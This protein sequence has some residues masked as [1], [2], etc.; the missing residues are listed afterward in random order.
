MAREPASRVATRPRSRLHPRWDA[1]AELA[2]AQHGV[3]G[4]FQLLDLG[5]QPR[6]IS[7]LLAGG[8]L[9]QIHRGVY[10]VGHRKL[11]RQGWRMAAVLSGGEGAALSHRPAG[12]EWQL[13][14]WSGRQTITVPSWR[15]SSSEIDFRCSMPA[16]DE[17]TVLDGIPITTVPRTLLDLAMVL[18]PDALLVAV[19]VAEA[20]GMGD[21]LS[22]P[23][24]LERH[25]GERGTEA[26]RIRPTVSGRSSGRSSSCTRP[27]GM[28]RSPRSH[29][30]R[31]VTGGC[32]SPTT[33]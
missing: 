21:T 10:A 9:H 1:I 28:G 5:F 23:D 6:A 14:N 7:R 32:S 16:P 24:M 31:H 17:I 3:A 20:R 33:G 22:L 30:T 4:R 27:G 15:R 18:N 8:H 11:S 13:R 29:V 25:R 12:D 19:N 26:S 2:L